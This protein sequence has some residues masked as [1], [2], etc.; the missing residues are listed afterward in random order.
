[1]EFNCIV[2][3]TYK[4]TLRNHCAAIYSGGCRKCSKERRFYNKEEA[5]LYSGQDYDIDTRDPLKYD[6]ERQIPGYWM[7]TAI[8]LSGRV[9]SIAT[10]TF[11]QVTVWPKSKG[12][13]KALILRSSI[14]QKR[15][16][17]FLA[18]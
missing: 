14:E 17:L 16:H 2:H 12:K 10:D 9:Y 7:Y 18:R 4:A 6:V 11:I 8:S 3:G 1:M 5:Q 13:R 15:T